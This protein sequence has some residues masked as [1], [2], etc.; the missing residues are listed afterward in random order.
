MHAKCHKEY[1]SQQAA[2]PVKN[3]SLASFYNQL[4]NPTQSKVISNWTCD[5]CKN[6][7]VR[8]RKGN[9]EVFKCALCSENKPNLAM[10]LCNNICNS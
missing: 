1:Y 10:K 5:F 4:T 3:Q 8:L 2:P 9:S 7:S 6:E